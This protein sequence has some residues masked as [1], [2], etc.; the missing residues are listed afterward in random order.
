MTRWITALL[1]LLA[2]ALGSSH[3]A[4]MAQVPMQPAQPAAAAPSSEIACHGDAMEQ[5][6]AEKAQTDRALAG[7]AP[8]KK[9]PD[10]CLD[11]C[12]GGCL[13]LAAFWPLPEL[14]HAVAPAPALPAFRP[15]LPPEAGP[16][17]LKRPP[18][19]LV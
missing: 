7:K 13:M 18:R 4:A 1:A 19:L 6:S 14:S 2:L 3:A 12:A 8:A 5:S 17:G 15:S 11:G 16:D 10:C 9:A